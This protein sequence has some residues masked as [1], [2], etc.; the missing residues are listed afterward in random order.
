MVEETCKQK[1]EEEEEEEEEK[2]PSQSCEKAKK[3]LNLLRLRS[4]HCVNLDLSLFIL[5]R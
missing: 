2:N 5:N 3:S 1:D 4:E